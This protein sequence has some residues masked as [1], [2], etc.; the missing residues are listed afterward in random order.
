MSKLSVSDLRRYFEV[1]EYRVDVHGVRHLGNCYNKFSDK[2]L[3]AWKHCQQQ[4]IEKNGGLLSIIA[5]NTYQ[6]TAGFIYV[7]DNEPYFHL[8]TPSTGGDYHISANDLC[9]EHAGVLR[10]WIKRRTK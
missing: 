6:F 4:C 8:E 7:K 10:E 1:Y 5:Y 3:H 2:K 9:D